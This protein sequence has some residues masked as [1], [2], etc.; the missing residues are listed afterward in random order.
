MITASF[1]DV[2]RISSNLPIF[3]KPEEPLIEVAFIVGVAKK[4]NAIVTDYSGKVL[5]E[6]SSYDLIQAAIKNRRDIW[7]ALYST[8][9]SDVV[10]EV[11]EV[12]AGEPLQIYYDRIRNSKFSSSLVFYNEKPLSLLTPLEIIPYLIKEGKLKNLRAE[13][14]ASEVKRVNPEITV[15]QAIEMMV[16]WWKRKLVIENKVI[17][18]RGI[19]EKGTFSIQMLNALAKDPGSVLGMKVKELPGI[20]MYPAFFDYEE[21][22]ESVAEKVL[23]TECYAA[24]SEDGSKIITPYDLAVKPFI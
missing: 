18:D 13:V 7:K 11:F 14:I 5:G 8:K 3:I 21:S 20:F 2:I 19:V 16:N 12:E 4:T 23:R 9:V 22:A 10:H 1:E 15:L 6:V 24:L 17:T